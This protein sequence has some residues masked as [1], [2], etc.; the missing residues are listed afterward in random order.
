MNT[1]TDVYVLVLIGVATLVT[2]LFVW[3]LYLTF[4]LRNVRKAYSDLADNM[5]GVA[6]ILS[7][8]KGETKKWDYISKAVTDAGAAQSSFQQLIGDLQ[9]RCEY[10]ESKAAETDR[11]FNEAQLQDPDSRMYNRAVKMVKSGASI[12]D[13][14]EECELP[15]A[16]A[17]L[18]ISIHGGGLSRRS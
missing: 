15:E 16:E 8:F 18:L 6:D 3:V 2:I 12:Q 1:G 13:I 14:M 5:N 10:L 17:K 7:R 4:L 9:N 11:R